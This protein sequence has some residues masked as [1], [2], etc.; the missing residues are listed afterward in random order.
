MCLPWGVLPAN[1]SAPDPL[2][3]A[4]ALCPPCPPP[5]CRSTPS[6]PAADPTSQTTA[7]VVLNGPPGVTVTK[8][9]LKLCPQPAGPC[10]ERECKNAICKVEGLTA[11]T[12]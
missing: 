12:K 11:C 7:T 9:L 6:I 8:F 2:T 5:P 4:R 3:C 1:P 10:L